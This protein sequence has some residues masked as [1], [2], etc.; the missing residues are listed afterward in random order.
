MA[1]RLSIISFGT[2]KIYSKKRNKNRR[3]RLVSI[4]F[5]NNNINLK[6]NQHDWQN[7]TDTNEKLEVGAKLSL[8]FPN[9]NNQELNQL[10]VSM[11]A[12]WAEIL[13]FKIRVRDFF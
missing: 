7:N 13:A 9:P 10:G 3:S 4:V 6:N 1:V 5:H 2:D 8:V 11:C 12:L